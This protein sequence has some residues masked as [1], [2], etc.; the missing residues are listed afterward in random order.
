MNT[1]PEEMQEAL[2]L[3]RRAGAGPILTRSLSAW[4][5]PILDRMLDRIEELERQ[6]RALTPPK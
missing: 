3:A 1:T 4:M 2:A 6:V 5:T